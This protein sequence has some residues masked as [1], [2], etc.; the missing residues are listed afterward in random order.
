MTDRCVDPF[1]ADHPL[2][3]PDRFAGRRAQVD[4]VADSLFQTAN[5]I[6]RHTIVTGDR[7]IGKSSL[8]S[9]AAN[10]AKVTANS[11]ID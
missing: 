7:G 4:A 2:T 10:L 11:L 8:L 3:D 6:G 1:S 9:Q 5:G